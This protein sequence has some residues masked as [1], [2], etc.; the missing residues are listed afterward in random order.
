MI[1]KFQRTDGMGN[2]LNGV[3]DRM[4]KII[5]GINAP[6]VSG[7]VVGHARHA[8]DHRVPHVDIRRSHVDL[9]PEYLF[10]VLICALAHLLK[11]PQVL[12]YRTLPV[13]AVF[14][15]LGQGPPVCPD[16]LRRQVADI[17]PA[18]LD[19]P[20]GAFIHL[21]KI[22]R[23]EIQAVFPVRSQPSDVLHDGIHKL[24]LFL[25]GV[26]VVKPHIERAVVLPGQPVIQQYGFGMSDMQVAV[27]F[28]REPGTYMIVHSF[29]KVFINL[30]LY[31]IL[32]YNVVFHSFLLNPSISANYI[33]IICIQRQ[34]SKRVSCVKKAGPLTKTSEKGPAF[35][36]LTGTL[37]FH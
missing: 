29:R 25:G 32:R 10:P 24:Y 13:R 26:C 8:V 21:V 2:P 7:P 5:H 1:L 4:S 36:Q 35:Q 12:I 30:L 34:G 37:R 11:Q 27:G 3:L 17:C 23:R 14:S 33:T 19:Q 22:I 28:R 18:F 20:D 16:L 6:F 31:K 15:G 9:R